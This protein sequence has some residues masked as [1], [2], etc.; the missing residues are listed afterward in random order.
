MSGAIE[1]APDDQ[2]AVWA[3]S[4]HRAALSFRAAGEESRPCNGMRSLA[5]LGMTK[6][7]G[8]MTSECRDDE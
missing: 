7:K 5:S 6:E 1:R 2:A 8:G 4:V 3:L